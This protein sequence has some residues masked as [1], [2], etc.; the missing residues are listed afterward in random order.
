VLLFVWPLFGLNLDAGRTILAPATTAFGVLVLALV[1]ARQ[2]CGRRKRN[3]GDFGSQPRV[4]AFQT[5]A[6]PA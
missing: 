3:V 1:T 4:E 5:V 6:G 2:D